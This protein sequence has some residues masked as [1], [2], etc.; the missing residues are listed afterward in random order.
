MHDL[1]LA[2]AIEAE[3]HR[4]RPYGWYR[5]PTHGYRLRT[6]NGHLLGRCSGCAGEAA[7]GIRKFKR[8]EATSGL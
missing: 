7:I 1:D 5:C 2:D 4:R 8:K 3:R 6:Y